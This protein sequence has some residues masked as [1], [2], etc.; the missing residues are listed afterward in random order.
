MA[1]PVDIDA[2]LAE[3]QARKGPLCA[4]STL[5]PDAR[6][7]AEILL[8]DKRV[9]SSTVLRA[10]RARYAVAGVSEFVLRRHRRGICGCKK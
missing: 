2:V 7:F 10:L 9:Q 3:F 6:V 4:V 1:E 5:A 8:A